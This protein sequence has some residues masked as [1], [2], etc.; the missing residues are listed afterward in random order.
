MN[1]GGREGDHG[2][3]IAGPLHPVTYFANHNNSKIQVQKTISFSLNFELLCH[4]FPDWG[5]RLTRD[6]VD[7]RNVFRRQVNNFRTLFEGVSE[8]VLLRFRSAQPV[9]PDDVETSFLDLLDAPFDN[10]RN[11]KAARFSIENTFETRSEESTAEAS[12]R[13][14]DSGSGSRIRGSEVDESEG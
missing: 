7:V 13:S 8:H 1:T 6:D 3:G 9:D 10:Q 5:F 2:E 14:R 12:E 11:R 4:R